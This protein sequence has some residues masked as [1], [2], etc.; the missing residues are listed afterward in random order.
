VTF[1]VEAG[2]Q[3]DHDSTLEILGHAFAYWAIAEE[4]D[5]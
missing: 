1:G 3:L 2:I 4:Q 5:G